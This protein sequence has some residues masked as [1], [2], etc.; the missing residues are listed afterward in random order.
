MLVLSRKL[1]ECFVINDEAAVSIA[2]IGRGFVELSITDLHGN[3][4]GT[5]AISQREL[6][7]VFA[8][9]WAVV[10]RIAGDKVR[11]GLESRAG[12]SIDRKENWSPTLRF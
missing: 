3:F 9:V 6:S 11:L 10:V 8:G 2:V 12:G 4:R 1:G 5:A 7:P